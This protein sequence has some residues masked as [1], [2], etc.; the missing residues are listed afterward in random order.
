MDPT[1]VN[2]V[3]AAAVPATDKQ[4]AKP[5]II[6][7]AIVIGGKKNTPDLFVFCRPEEVPGHASLTPLSVA[8]DDTAKT[9]NTWH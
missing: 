1:F 9:A 5:A 7:P 8:K 4:E 2:Y 6:R 3:V